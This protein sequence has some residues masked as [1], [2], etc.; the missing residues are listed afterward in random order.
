MADHGSAD[1]GQSVHRAP[2]IKALPKDGPSFDIASTHPY[3][4]IAPP[5]A[6]CIRGWGKYAVPDSLAAIRK[7]LP[8]GVPVWYTEVGWQIT[9]ADGGHY[10]KPAASCVPALL[11]AAY[12]VRLYAMAMRLGVPRVTNMFLS[13]TDGYNGGFFARDHAARPSAKA[14]KTMIAL[15]PH[16]KLTAVLAEVTDG[17]YAYRFDPD[18]RKTGD[19]PVVMAWRVGG[20]KKITLDWPAKQAAAV[21]MFGQ[22]LPATVRNGKLTV[23]VGPCP[24]YIRSG[25]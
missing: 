6:Y 11:Q 3:T 25:K 19:A 8:A 12:T 23:E 16:P 14:V 15:L 20:P 17:V 7:N 10:D 18:T 21:D 13:D 4:H 9:K 2:V 5:D 22:P 24:V 1:G